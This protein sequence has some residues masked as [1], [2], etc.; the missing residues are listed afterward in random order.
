MIETMTL[1]GFNEVSAEP[2]STSLPQQWD[3]PR[4]PKILPESVESMVIARPKNLN[5][6]RKP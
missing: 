4:D 3:K 1:C 6:K 5:Q 2:S